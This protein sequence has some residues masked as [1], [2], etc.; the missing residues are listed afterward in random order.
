VSRLAVFGYGSLASPASAAL[1]L[2]REVQYAGLCRLRGWRRRWTVYRDN[3]ISEKTFALPDGTIPPFVVGLNLERDDGAEGANGVLIEISE[4]EA[5]R[6]DMREMRYDRIE[7]TDDVEG[8]DEEFGR[9]IAYTA[10][11]HHH[12]PEPPAGAVVVAAYVQTV[13]EAFAEL[14]PAELAAYR[15]STD[16]PPVE[17]M[18]VALVAD[19]IPEGNPRRW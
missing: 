13:E 17:P 15:A 3:T 14:G 8:A 5:D 12:A 19:E 1:T 18:E 16:P 2:G 7:V 9:V 4:A 10:K 11:A 6:L